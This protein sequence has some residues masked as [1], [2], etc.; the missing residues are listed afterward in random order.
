MVTLYDS[1]HQRYKRPFGAAAINQTTYFDF[2]LN[3]EGAEVFGVSLIA[4]KY[5]GEVINLPMARGGVIDGCDVYSTDLI[6]SEEGIYFYRF[7]IYTAQGTVFCGRAEGG[8]A[9]IGRNFPEWQLTVYGGFLGRRH[10]LAGGVIY[11]IFA[12]RFKKGKTDREIFKKGAVFKDDW[13]EPPTVADPDGVFRA[14]DFYGGNVEGIIEEL[15]YIESLGVTLIY[16][17][18]IFEAA[19]NHRYDTGD[20]F[21]IDGIFGDESGFARLIEEAKKRGIYIMIDGVFNHTGSDSKYFNKYGNYP[22]VGA[23]QSKDSEYY[24]WYNFTSYPDAY[25]CWWGITVSPT[26]KKDNPKVRRL[27]RDVI[28]KWFAFGVKG[29]RL[30]VADELPKDYIY[31]IRRTLKAIDGESYLLGEVWEDASVKI[32]YGTMRPYL[33]GGQLDSVM[34][35]PFKDAI[36]NYVKGGG[37][38][39]FIETVMS[40]LENYPEYCASALMNIIDTH[41]TVRAVNYFLE[42]DYSGLTAAQKRRLIIPKDD[43]LQAYKKIKTA[44]LLQFTLPGI[45]SVYYGDE[46]GLT[47]FGD[48][49]NRA[50]YPFGRENRGLLE[51][52]RRLGAFRREFKD[53]LGSIRFDFDA[54]DGVLV[55]KIADEKAAVVV[56]GSGKKRFYTADCGARDYLSGKRLE[57]GKKIE[58][59]AGEG[60]L[61]VFDKG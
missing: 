29:L 34:N 36:L 41:D 56:N 47:G 38:E 26:L 49:L 15:D 1:R 17:S 60:F 45:P 23:Y 52:Y 3:S 20:Y 42:G 32:S 44:A 5:T 18:P 40:I 28:K 33:L 12:D 50:A 7:E 4:R 11:H 21:K 27:V 57:K 22:T 53:A 39:A 10:P 48:P 9:A 30:D 43:L 46:A 35:Y 16:L 37:R 13:F 8:K 14:N 55:Y 59:Q 24:D 2:F 6:L 31:D 25:D 19:S 51:F 58:M 61:P 54:D